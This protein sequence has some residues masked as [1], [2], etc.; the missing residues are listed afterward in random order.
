MFGSKLPEPIGRREHVQ[1]KE[2]AVEACSKYVR[3]KWPRVEV[4]NA[5]HGMVVINYY[6]SRGCLLSLSMF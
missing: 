4:R 1:V 3:E 5:S 6:V 2:Q